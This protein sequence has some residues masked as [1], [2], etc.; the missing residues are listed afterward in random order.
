MAWGVGR[1]NCFLNSNPYIILT[2]NKAI[3][4]LILFR[5]Q[6]FNKILLIFFIDE[7]SDKGPLLLSSKFLE[8][9]KPIS[10]HKM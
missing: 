4:I 8:E 9:R 1:L 5:D 2:L 6:L 3:T 7:K 10:D